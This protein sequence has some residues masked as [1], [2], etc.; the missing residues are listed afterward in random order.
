[1]ANVRRELQRSSIMS[2]FKRM[3]ERRASGPGGDTSGE[4]RQD[5][6]VVREDPVHT[7]AVHVES[8]EPSHSMTDALPDVTRKATDP[9]SKQMDTP[10]TGRPKASLSELKRKDRLLGNQEKRDDNKI[11]VL[12]ALYAAME[13]HHFVP[14]IY[15]QDWARI[16]AVWRGSRDFNVSVNIKSGTTIDF[17]DDRK[18]YS[19]EELMA[20]LEFN[21]GEVHI[22]RTSGVEIENSALQRV[23][24]SN[25]LWMKG[26]SLR[27]PVP[28]TRI[29][30]QYLKSRGIPDVVIDRIAN[31]VRVAAS[32]YG[33]A[34]LML[35]IY[36]PTKN[37]KIVG[38][39]R[40]YLDKDGNKYGEDP[41]RMIGTH[42][43]RDMACGFLIAGDRERFSSH[44]VALVEG[45][46]TGLA[47]HAATGMPVY[48]LY[49]SNGI[50]AACIEYLS[51]LGA[52]SILIATDNDDPDKY[53]K[54]AGQDSSRALA[55]RIVNEHQ[56]P[57]RIAL[58]PRKYTDGNKSDWLDIWNADPAGT[59]KMILSAPPFKLEES[60]EPEVRTRM[61]GIFK[62]KA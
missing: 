54:R 26:A 4:L 2:V 8:R 33:G 18:Q 11:S 40:I 58:P 44:E 47:V 20:L 48:V 9:V 53:G 57:V 15:G 41:K 42:F 60:I 36:Q 25:G 37:G 61:R 17:A 52:Q 31:D 38:L 43:Y 39:Q 23:R 3:R 49:N 30:R 32:D 22:S 16:P 59:G 13:K 56:S 35:P 27:T 28:E 7:R 24:Y 50:K 12:D 1:M 55:T 6:S 62:K 29:A 19:F 34:Y 46:E 45:F 10:K 51:G 21:P 5:G 14:K